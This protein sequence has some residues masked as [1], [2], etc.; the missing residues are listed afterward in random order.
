[1]KKAVLATLTLFAAYWLQTPVYAQRAY[2]PTDKIL[3]VGISLGTY[4]YGYLGTRS[5]G[6]LP[7]TASLEKGLPDNSGKGITDKISVGGY[8]GYASWN[9]N[10]AYKFSYKYIS[11]GAKG[12]FH[13]TEL[14]NESLDLGINAD[15]LDLYGSL[16]VGMEL[17]RFSSE[18]TNASYGNTAHF[19]IGP[20]L[21]ARYLFTPKVGAFF[22]G[23]RGALGYGT[24]G[25]T[26]RF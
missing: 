14:L 7:I 10:Y 13:A 5:G 3:N 24:F 15:K 19:R 12:S 16:L 18:W 11:F 25:V 2:E 1:M 20:V 8:V 23:G 6:F 9:Y 4:G 22:E 17:R 26:A 21:G